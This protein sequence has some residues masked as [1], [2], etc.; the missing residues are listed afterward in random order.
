MSITPVLKNNFALPIA[1]LNITLEY[2][3]VLFFPNISTLSSL[4]EESKTCESQDRKVEN[5][6]GG[7]SE[8]KIKKSSYICLNVMV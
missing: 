3:E 6:S 2:T 1:D 7:V 4:S 8:A 5:D